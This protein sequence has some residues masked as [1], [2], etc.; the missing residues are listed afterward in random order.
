VLSENRKLFFLSPGFTLIE[1]LVVVAILG[2]LA[3]VGIIAYGSYTTTTKMSAASNTMQQISLAQT[4][5]FSDSDSYW[6]D[7][8]SS[9]TPTKATTIKIIDEDD[10]LGVPIPYKDINFYFCIYGDGTDYTIKALADYGSKDCEI[11][12]ALETQEAVRNDKC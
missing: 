11:T 7:G 5:Y 9:C 1:L 4:E 6:V 3:S 12:F 8:A 10:G 2:V